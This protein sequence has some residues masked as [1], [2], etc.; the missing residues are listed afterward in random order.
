MN[1]LSATF[2]FSGTSAATA[3]A[4]ASLK[5][6]KNGSAKLRASF[7]GALKSALSGGVTLDAN[8]L[9]VKALLGLRFNGS[10]Y[11]RIIPLSF[12]F[13]GSGQSAK[14]K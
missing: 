12:T 5:L 4:K 9:P 13:T 3:N 8:G 2:V 7:T 6:G 14:F 1:G 11:S 10:S